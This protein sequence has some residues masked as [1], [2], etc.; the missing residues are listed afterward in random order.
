V[1]ICMSVRKECQGAD[2]RC[3]TIPTDRND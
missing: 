3:G 2:K 1:V